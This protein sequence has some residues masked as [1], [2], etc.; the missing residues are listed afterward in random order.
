MT[1][2]AAF[3]RGSLVRASNVRAVRAAAALHAGLR[4]AGAHRAD[5]PGRREI[6]GL[7]ACVSLLELLLEAPGEIDHAFVTVGV[8]EML[9]GLRRDPVVGPIAGPA[10][11]RVCI[12][13]PAPYTPPSRHVDGHAK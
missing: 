8:G 6:L 4:L 2:G 10:R 5:Q 7:P 1:K 3:V 11:G 13:G 12:A 9:P